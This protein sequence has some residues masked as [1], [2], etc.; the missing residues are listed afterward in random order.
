[1]A[2]PPDRGV[3]LVIAIVDYG[4]GNLLSVFNA[5]DMLGADAAICKN[6]GD[7]AGAERIVLPGVGAFVDCIKNLEESGFAEALSQQVLGEGKP[8]FG[9][10]LGMQ[11]MARMGFEGGGRTGLGWF[12][13]DV[14][15]LTPDDPSLRVPHVG[16]NDVT[17]RKG[18]P[19]FA[20]IPGA[21]D[22]Y[23]VHSYHMK[24]DDARDVEAECEY[25]GKVTAAVR[26][27][28]IFATQFHPEKSQDHGLAVLGDF[29]KWQPSC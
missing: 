29:L 28:N 21:A 12:E 5:L 1:V 14:V 23:F 4:M 3:R 26:K 11:V 27:K 24:C 10:C 22:F 25:G 19:L 8:I 9:I 18:S 17:H 20:H 16:W 2:P 6:P 15:R 13:A 7:L